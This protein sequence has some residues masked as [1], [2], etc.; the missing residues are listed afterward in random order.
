MRVEPQDV[1]L[2]GLDEE[3]RRLALSEVETEVERL[4]QM[5]LS[6]VLLSRVLL[7]S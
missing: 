3:P 6:W 1:L 4:S 5:L 7:D 2:Q